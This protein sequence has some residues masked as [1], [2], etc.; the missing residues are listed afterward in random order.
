MDAKKAK[1]KVNQWVRLHD[2]NISQKVKVII[3]HF[4][5]NVMGLLGGQAKAMVVTSSRKEAVR[6][7]LAFDKYVTEQGYQSI[8]AMVAFSGEVEFTDSDP[9]S[10]AL[11]GQKFTE[12]SMNPNLKGREM[13]KAFDSDDYQVML[14]A[15]KFQ[16]GFD[17][18]KLCAMY[19]DK[20]L[21]GVECVQ[22]LSR[23]NRTYPGKAESGTFVL[24]FFN[25]PDEILEAF[26]PYYQ[27][28]ELADVTDPDKVFE[29]FNKLK[30]NGIFLWSEVEQFATA[31]F[32]RN[33]S[34]AVL[35]NI[36]KPAIERWQQR[37]NKAIAAYSKSKDMLE[38]CK[39]SGDAVLVGNAEKDF[40]EAKKAK[41]ELEIF[42]KDLGTFT[43]FY[44]FM[45]QIV[46]YDD[47]ELEKLSLFARN[48]RPML[49]EN[50]ILDDEIDLSNVEMSHYR[51]SK[52]RQMD[53]ELQAN[54]REHQL[55]PSNDVGSAT[56]KDKKE[57]F[58]SNILH[59]L[60]EVFVTDKLTDQDMLNYATTIADKVYENNGVMSQIANNTREQAL[61]GD[62]PRAIDDAI[63]GSHEAHREQMM[64]L[65]S[66]P[67]KARIFGHLIFDML[68]NRG[69]TPLR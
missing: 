45:S 58:L 50:I 62:F 61:L 41:D 29:L 31:F 64:Q 40:S 15:N 67:S 66:D 10:S 5:K 26:Q 22:T 56:A 1:L 16:T 53:I 65:L 46:D 30:S 25:E 28:A 63:L 52:L 60:N 51:L 27:T 2:H 68:A 18:P 13:R 48:L 33:K 37:Y 44:E 19:V 11:V 38:R 35:A 43:R 23:L 47:K 39:Q 9:N 32:S 12:H 54:S 42:K 55:E 21:G 69:Q 36:C 8:Q 24:D 3:E 14:V 49:R 4:K 7:K 59:R 6:Y 34:N 20:K 57:D 17:Q